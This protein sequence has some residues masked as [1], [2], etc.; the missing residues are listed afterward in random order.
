MQDIYK[1]IEECNL[2]NKRKILIVLDDMIADI[3]NI[4]ELNPIVTELVIR[5]RK[6]DISV[7]TITQSYFRVPKDVRLYTFF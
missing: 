7:V 2:R 1:N 6:I 4:K 5:G 3:I